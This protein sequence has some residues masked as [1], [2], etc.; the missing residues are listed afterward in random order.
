MAS[1]VALRRCVLAPT[2][3][4][5]LSYASG[6]PYISS[7]SSRS[8]RASAASAAA[9]A[10]VPKVAQPSFWKLLIPKPLRRKPESPFLPHDDLDPKQLKAA[11]TKEWN[12]ATFFIVI[13]LLIG[14]M[15]IQMIV[16][17]KDFAAFARQTDVRIG[18]L[19]DVVDKIQKGQ[20]VDVE[21]ALGTGDAER[22]EQWEEVLKEIERENA[23]LGKKRKQQQ[24]QQQSEAIKT[25][26][27][28]EAEPAS[29]TKLPGQANF[30]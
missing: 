9:S 29:D 23:V 24:Q 6:T 30:Y 26:P 4:I 27:T 7:S 15:S 20:K 19:R 2:D 16:L 18:L 21:R 17:K 8:S 11:K 14:S 3:R 12:P 5:T 25:S 1:R 13:F 22:E 28:T 10:V